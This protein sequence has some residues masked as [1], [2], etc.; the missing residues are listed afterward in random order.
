[1]ARIIAFANQKG[2]VGK[3]TSAINVASFLALGGKHVLVVDIDPQANATQGFGIN[4]R[5]LERGIYNVLVGQDNIRNTL[6]QTELEQLHIAPATIALAGATIE[7]VNVAE[8]EYK[9]DQ[10]LQSIQMYY[11][12]IIVDCPPSLDLLTLNGLVAARWI[13]IPVQCEYY[14]LEGLGQLLATI[15]LVQQNLQSQLQIGG[16]IVTMFDRR[17]A[18]SRQVIQE[19]QQHFPFH[20]FEAVIPRNVTLAEAPS[21]GKPIALYEP[22]STGGKAYRRLADEII[23][24]VI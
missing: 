21:Y 2:G 20:V 10:A 5:Q 8:R 6:F 17:N 19:V 24:R 4:P 16:A 22:R 13:M 9:L 1:M 12:Y 18:L 23:Q 11:D 14:A 15:E 3:T 7:L